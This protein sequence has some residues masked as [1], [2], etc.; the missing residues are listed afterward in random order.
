MTIEFRCSQ[1]SQLLRVPDDAAGKNARCPKCQALMMV[2]AEA[3]SP[4]A[5]EVPTSA[6]FGALPS[7]EMPPASQTFIPP[8]SDPFAGSLGGKPPEPPLKPLGDVPLGGTPASPFAAQPGVNLNPYAPPSEAAFGYGAQF[9]PPGQRPGLPWEYKGQSLSTWWETSKLCLMQP[10]Y[11]YSIMRQYGGMGSPMMFCAVGLGIGTVGQML[12]YVPLMLAVTMAGAQGQAKGGEAA[13][14][15]GVQIVSQG[16]SAIFTVALGATIGLMIG[17]GIVH[18]CLMIVGGAKQGYETSLRVLGF[19]QGSTA[20]MNVI[21]CGALVAFVWVL[22]QEIIGLARAHETTTGKAAMAV[23][24]PMVV[25]MGCMAAIIAI[26]VVG[27][28][29]ASG[30]FGK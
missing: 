21:P 26:F 5:G 15:A 10:T 13:A 24:L 23:V 28:A 8:P 27:I 20:W 7:E 3:A 17:A 1:C 14:L 19:A 11:A 22:A 30:A 25:C 18:V 9:V 6:G 2:P 16:I 4:P 29:G 12:W